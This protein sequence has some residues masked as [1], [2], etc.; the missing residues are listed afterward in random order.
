MSELN[1]IFNILVRTVRFD[2]MKIFFI[3]PENK[4]AY[5]K[6]IV[7]MFKNRDAWMTGLVEKVSQM[8]LS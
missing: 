3:E 8:M 5:V 7:E 1:L 4:I 2:V 6:F